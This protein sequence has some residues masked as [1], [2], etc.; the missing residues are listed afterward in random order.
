MYDNYSLSYTIPFAAGKGP[1]YS[2]GSTSMWLDLAVGLP[3]TQGHLIAPFQVDT[4]SVG[5]VVPSYMVPHYVP[6]SQL[7]KL[8]FSSS[9]N[10]AM[11]SWATMAVTFTDGIPV[12]GVLPTAQV[13]VFIEQSAYYAK[14]GDT[15][16]C[17]REVTGRGCIYQLGVGYGRSG[18][19]D[20]FTPSPSLNP[21]LNIAGM[22]G[23]NPTI[24]AGYMITAD[25]I[26]AGLT[27]E[28]AGSGFAYVKL[29]PSTAIPG[30][31]QTLPG[32][33]YV[34]QQQVTVNNTMLLD[35][36][37]S[38][39]WSTFGGQVRPVTCPEDSAFTCAPSGTAFT[40]VLG[41][42]G[43]P[44]Q[45]RYS[46]VEG[47]AGNS[48]LAPWY[49]RVNTVPGEVN[50]GVHA[51]AGFTYF[52]DAAGGYVGFQPAP[53]MEDSIVFNA[54]LAVTGT[55]ALNS[56]FSSDIPVFVADATT[57]LTPDAAL[58]AGDVTGNGALNIGGPGTVMFTGN[59]TLPSGIL[60][61]SGGLSLGGATAANIQVSAQTSLANSGTL[62]GA[63]TNAGMFA[64]SGTMIGALTSS[65][66]VQ[67]TGQIQGSVVN[68]GS[69]AN[70]ASGVL[71]GNFSN[72][73]FFG[74]DGTLTGTL[75]NSATVQ[76]TGQIQGSVINSGVFTNSGTQTGGVQN[77]GTLTNSG[78]LA[79]PLS[80]SGSVQNGG[81]IQGN[82][83]NG[84]TFANTGTLAGT[85]TNTANAQNIGLIQGGAVNSGSF[86]N[87]GTL[88]GGLTNTAT[89]QNAGRIEG[90]V[91][92]SST[93]F[94]S[95]VV[96]GAFSNSA[97]AQ[98][99]GQIQGDVLNTGT[100][101]NDGTVTGT[102]TNRALLIGNGIIKGDL[103][104]SGRVSPGHSIGTIQVNG[105]VSLASTAVYTAEIGPNGTSDLL[106]ATGVLASDGATLQVLA[107]PG[108]NPTLGSSYTLMTAGG[109]VVGSFVLDPVHFGTTS[110]LYPFLAIEVSTNNGV[111]IGLARSP[112]PFA[113]FA[114]T[115]NQ[116]AVAA[117]ADQLSSTTPLAAALAGVTA[118]G[119]PVAFAQ[120]DGDVYASA[121][122]VL[123][124]QS[125]YV[126]NAVTGRL[127]Q[128][129]ASAPAGA[130]PKAVDMPG[131]SGATLWGQAYAG[132]GANDGNFN[133]SGT[134]SSIGGFIM[135][136]DTL[137]ADWRVGLAAGF[138]QSQYDL[139]SATSSGESDNYDLA[140]YAGRSFGA[141]NLRFG[142]AYSWHDMSSQR[143]VALP[144]LVQSYSAGYDGDTA[145][146]FGEVGYGFLFSGFGVPVGIEPFA[147]LS[148]VALSTDG[149]SEGVGAAA[150]T[151]TGSDFDTLSTTLG[152]RGAMTVAAGAMPVTLTGTLGW[153]HDFG[154]LTP[155][156]TLAFTAGASP[157]TIYGAPLASDA[158]I[159]AAGLSAQVSQNLSVGVSYSG[160][161]S[162]DVTENAVK[163][164]VLWAF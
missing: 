74:N 82:V 18:K 128:G 138:S 3:G 88:T 52:Y 155:A 93:F 80:N 20:S 119:A 23:A 61:S 46:Y 13:P 89:A 79:G 17:S 92:N 142:A 48:E 161:I 16:E 30:D 11:G 78:T 107:L 110:S 112:V 28:N 164:S 72:T 159:A 102:V 129:T 86:A 40:I 41:A 69:F 133:A 26:V 58:F 146:A 33:F 111:S 104:S 149:F 37:L 2:S 65:G 101:S 115:P 125:A 137:M 7:E 130:G 60:V 83:V 71:S 42:A 36:G 19:G 98:S 15:V 126:R 118:T 121:Q 8:S 25:G 157:F 108:F 141:F 113:A 85:L 1:D 94:T 116:M 144:N 34:N 117:A 135:G 122:S 29:Q 96:V 163:G 153:Q 39:L 75:T 24:R 91:V 32:Q 123:Q 47:D 70:S 27:K 76:S 22:T 44:N 106:S 67:N 114:I 81:Q 38:Y 84:G 9:N 73:G 45:I 63:V 162:S 151:G 148:Y 59:V 97:N 31:W 95:G 147:G 152:V 127:L 124:Q 50:T 156:S 54:S 132:W 154:D 134:S 43:N 100:F 150:L 145:Q 21:L 66:S 6:P 99:T 103:V 136:L 140:L 49:S 51:F 62:T 87:G 109:G 131:I 68:S 143:T 158:L 55:V 10:Y 12:N 4:G 5:M 120:L 139:N 77:S 160:Q 90:G 56:G 35:S 105:N 57:L 14:T 53:G 64:N